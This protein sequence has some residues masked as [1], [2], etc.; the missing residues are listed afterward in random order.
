MVDRRTDLGETEGKYSTN[1]VIQV[2]RKD[3]EQRG[4]TSVTSTS[5]SEKNGDGGVLTID[6]VYE[7]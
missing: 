4:E 1:R 6:G 2:S 7:D 5:V 3:L